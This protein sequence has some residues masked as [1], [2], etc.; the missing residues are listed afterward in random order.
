[1]GGRFARCSSPRTR[2]CAPQPC[3]L[4]WVTAAI[5]I[6]SYRTF[7][8]DAGQCPTAV[9]SGKAKHAQFRWACDHRL[10]AAFCTL[11]DASRR[12]NPW[13]ADIY[14]RA[15]ARGASPP[16]HPHPRTH[17]EP[18]H[19]A[20]RARPRHLRPP[21]AHRASSQREVDTGGLQAAA[22]VM[23]QVTRPRRAPTRDPPP[24]GEASGPTETMPQEVREGFP[25]LG[26]RLARC[27]SHAGRARVNRTP[28]CQA[29]R[30]IAH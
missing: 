7:A 10:R 1:M 28:L 16:S 24:P 17:L 18:N 21:T 26:S 22:S 27:T 8:A 29:A 2:G 25:P 11:A 14:K 5:A 23:G 20:P 3:C 15:R 9:E 12:H 6:P 4:R 13:A 30:T 19:L